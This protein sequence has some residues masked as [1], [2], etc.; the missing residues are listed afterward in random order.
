MVF[1][2]CFQPT[3]AGASGRSQRAFVD[4][5]LVGVFCG[6]QGP[7]LPP[8]EGFHGVGWFKVLNHGGFLK[9]GIPKTMGFNNTYNTKT[10]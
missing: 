10:V 9:W 8:A 2:P 6:A 1:S 7:R 4:G 5:S 3:T